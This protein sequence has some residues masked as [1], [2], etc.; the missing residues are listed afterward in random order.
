MSFIII[1]FSFIFLLFGVFLSFY[2]IKNYEKNIDLKTFDSI[3][4]K[5][6]TKF[7]YYKMDDRNNIIGE[8][9]ELTDET[10]DSQNCIYADLSDIPDDLINAVISIEDKRFWTH[11][12][13][14]WK[15][16]ISA[17]FNYL[18]KTDYRFGGSTIT[19]QLIKNITGNDQ[20]SIDRKIQEMILSL[21]LETKLEKSEILEYYLNII[22]LSQGCIGVGA[23]AEVYFSKKI[24]ELSLLECVSL[25]AIT[26]NPSYYNPINNPENNLERRNI[27]LTQMLEQNYISKE[28]YDECINSELELNVKKKTININSWY[29]D[30]VIEDVIQDLCN[31]YGYTHDFASMMVYTGGL[32]IYTSMDY[33]IQNVIE[34]YYENVS[35]FPSGDQNNPLQSSMIIIHPETGDILGVAGAIG[36]KKGNRIQNYA[37]LT[38][39]PSGSVIK[40]LSVYALSI[41]EGIIS[42]ASVYDD[43]PVEFKYNNGE[44]IPWPSNSPSV[45]KGL[46]NI[47]AAVRDSV[48][49]VAIKVLN[50]LGLRKSF[51]FL[52]DELNIKNL[53]EKKILDN[54]N[55]ISDIG[56]SSLALGQQ[57]YGVT[58]REM[59]TAY[60]IF[61]NKGI[62]TN[63]RS[64]YKVTDIYGNILLEKSS[65]CKKIISL[66]TSSIMTL[67][68]EEVVKKG[69]A[70][71]IN[72]DKKIAVAGKTG[73]TQ[74]N[75]DKWFI[76]YTPYLLAGV[77]CGYEYPKSLDGIYGNPCLS[78]WDE[79]MTKIN[80][81]YT[82]NEYKLF[83]K[84]KNIVRIKVCAD[85]GMLPT[86]ACK[87]D[88]RGD[89]STFCWFIKGKEP[90]SYCNCHIEV[91][92]DIMNGGVLLGSYPNEYT[93]K[94]G[95]ITVS[96]SFPKQIFVSD[97][98]YVW[99]RM[100]ADILPICD[101]NL[102]FFNNIIEAGKYCGISNV[103]VQFNRGSFGH[104]NIFKRDEDSY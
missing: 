42:S 83:E 89:R 94:V 25:A 7:F 10:L 57:N 9:Y 22:N 76:G 74:N 33:D 44:Y 20:Y 45:Y 61:A 47:T 72:L 24:N 99:K 69:T 16:T 23:A 98:Q 104:N 36:A 49:T 81:M 82:N 18:I 48:N 64:Y 38:K 96:R 34:T 62:F 32:R 66:E 55:V 67:M 54:G 87:I 19:Q 103:P 91:D 35:N 71:A 43:V 27:I 75:Y 2:I 5:G 28:E 73:T 21:N 14:D 40:P 65:D 93:Q 12:G 1:I 92:Y 15:R 17:V 13:V 52:Y 39:R 102:P 26:N 31:K 95:M 101:Y 88:A 37:T 84:A 59:T 80:T 60:T 85:S 30:M 50:Q 86:N 41:E 4:N 63:S 51:D 53:I 79:V 70:S 78:A 6:T 11:K 68:L 58:V 77:W 3:L 46:T 29:V 8:I 56:I 90:S 100:P 97:A